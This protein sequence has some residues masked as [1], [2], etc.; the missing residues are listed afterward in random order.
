MT[1]I[2][3]SA[4]LNCSWRRNADRFEPRVGTARACLE[5]L[6]IGAGV[7]AG[8]IQHFAAELPVFLDL[9]F[10]LRG[11]SAKLAV[12]PARVDDLLHGLL[13]ARVIELQMD[14]EL[15]A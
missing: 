12:L 14:A 4:R 6:K 9:C 8:Q 2:N 15:G 1:S 5:A 11:P 10:R 7:R 3:Y 13:E